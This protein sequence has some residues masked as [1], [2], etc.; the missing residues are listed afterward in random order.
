MTM[1][2]SA[3]PPGVDPQQCAAWPE[4]LEGSGKHSRVLKK[5]PSYSLPLNCILNVCMVGCSWPLL[6]H[7]YI[8]EQTTCFICLFCTS[9]ND[10]RYPESHPYPIRKFA[11][12]HGV[13]KSRSGEAGGA[14][15]TWNLDSYNLGCGREGQSPQSSSLEP[16]NV[17]LCG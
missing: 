6:S 11:I 9:T 4:A 14:E 7:H 15:Q 16:A 1:G 12:S 5:D 17:A 2:R 8:L 3:A 10:W 13:V